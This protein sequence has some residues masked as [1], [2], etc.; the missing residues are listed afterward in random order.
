[1]SEQTPFDPNDAPEEEEERFCQIGHKGTT[2]DHIR[3]FFTCM[4][5]AQR[6]HSNGVPDTD[7][8][9][10]KL[11]REAWQE[12]R[13]VLTGIAEAVNLDWDEGYLHR[14][15]HFYEIPEDQLAQAEAAPDADA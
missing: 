1:M 15:A 7:E 10:D 3:N 8:I 6:R 14:L 11:M 5:L 2:A 4:M 9:Q 12:A 13:L